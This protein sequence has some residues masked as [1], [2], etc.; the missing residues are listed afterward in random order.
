VISDWQTLVEAKVQDTAGILSA[1]DYINA[2][3]EAVGLYSDD[4]PRERVTT[5]TGNGVAMDFALPADATDVVSVEYPVAQQEPEYLD[6][7][8]WLVMTQ[9]DDTQML[10]LT[11]LVLPN[12]APARVLYSAPHSVTATVDTVPLADRGAASNLAAAVCC[13]QLAAYYSQTSDS[14]IAADAV[15]Y[16]TKNQEYLALARAYEEAY[17]RAVTGGGR[18]ASVSKD[19]EDVAMFA[20][21]SGVPRFY[22]G[23]R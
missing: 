12:A 23:R 18:A 8:D 19:V 4:Y 3:A 11:A 22:H 20:Q 5:I 17:Q 1:M 2:I 10:H 16:R 13:R 6:E 14:T 9:P 21:G 7:D 15:N